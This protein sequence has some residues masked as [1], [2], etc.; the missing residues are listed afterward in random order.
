MTGTLRIYISNKLPGNTAAD[1][2]MAHGALQGEVKR[3][4]RWPGHETQSYWGDQKPVWSS[5]WE[6]SAKSSRDEQHLEVKGD[7]QCL[8]PEKWKSQ[9]SPEVH[10]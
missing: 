4:R 9:V 5:P 10:R 6:K 7:S 1:M 8:L 2:E 3:G